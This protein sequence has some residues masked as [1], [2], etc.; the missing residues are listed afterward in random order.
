M[1]SSSFRKHIGRVEN[2]LK[3]VLYAGNLLAINTYCKFFPKIVAYLGY[4]IR[5][6]ILVIDNAHDASAEKTLAFW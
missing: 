1:Y 2:T 6:R 5:R 3:R 4:F